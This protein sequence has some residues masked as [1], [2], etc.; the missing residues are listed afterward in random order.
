MFLSIFC[1][2]HLCFLALTNAAGAGLRFSLS[3]NF[4]Y[5]E[6][7]NWD[8][9]SNGIMSFRFQTHS[10]TALL[11]YHD[12]KRNDRGQDYMDVFIFKGDI[13]LRFNLGFCQET[14]E[15]TVLGDFADYKWHYVVI[16][17]YFKYISISV[18]KTSVSKIVK[19]KTPEHVGKFAKM[20]KRRWASV[21][22]GGIPLNR[23]WAYEDWSS[24]RIIK[25]AS[26][27]RFEGCIGDL[28]YQKDNQKAFKAK[29]KRKEAVVPDC[30]NAC[31]NN[32]KSFAPKCQNGGTCIDHIDN[33][34]CDCKGTGYEGDYCANESTMVYMNGSGFVPLDPNGIILYLGNPTDHLAVEMFEG[35][36]QVNINLGGGLLVMRSK[37]TLNVSEYHYVEITRRERRMTIDINKGWYIMEELTPGDLFSLDLKGNERVAYFGGGPDGKAIDLST[38]KRNFSGFLQ[39]LTFE[40]M[41]VLDKVMNYPQD[42]RF[43]KIG[44][45]LEGSQR[46]ELLPISDKI[47]GSGCGDLDDDEDMDR[48]TQ[49]TP[50][51]FSPDCIYGRVT[52]D[53]PPPP[54]T[55]PTTM[56]L[57]VRLT[58]GTPS[59]G[60]V[61]ARLESPPDH[62]V[63]PWTIII[64]VAAAVIAVIITIFLLYRWNIRY[65]G[66]FKPHKSEPIGEGAQPIGRG[67]EQPAFYV[68]S[69]KPTKGVTMA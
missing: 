27:S 14:S 6:Y 12:D 44:E 56:T 53:T 1:V 42:K 25:D 43:S 48:C 60:V 63:S 32:L 37:V 58:Y 52:T 30:F 64:I 29:L 21:Y 26:T 51:C 34:D 47:Q 36:I 8:F 31:K 38:S 54:T 20:R 22:L 19:C 41:K 15:L 23:K 3:R 2:V 39:E 65:T 4:P 45:V 40:T 9:T 68:S 50:R 49:P 33:F 24:A 61:L 10:R 66:S 18:D 11:L 28:M 16:T 5:A 55:K 46:T 7:E 13:R 67:Y 57:P 35:T 69:N 59:G 17:L 62:S